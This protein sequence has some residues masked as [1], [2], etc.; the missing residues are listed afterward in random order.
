M[1]DLWSKVQNEGQTFG[2]MTHPSGGVVL[3]A[4]IAVK[5]K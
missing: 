1:K 4:Q 5:A 3:E 2:N